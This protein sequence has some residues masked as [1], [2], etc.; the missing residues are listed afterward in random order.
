MECGIGKCGA[1][2]MLVDGKHVDPLDPPPILTVRLDSQQLSALKG[3]L[4][5]IETFN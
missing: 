3:Y 4:R 2:E 5:N 1:C